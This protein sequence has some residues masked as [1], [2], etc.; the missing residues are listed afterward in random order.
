MGGL[1]DTYAVI[2]IGGVQHI[3]E[4]GRWYTC[5][6]LEVGKIQTQR[7]TALHGDVQVLSRE[8][9]LAAVPRAQRRGAPNGVPAVQPCT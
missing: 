4:E 8:W 5:N 9:Q 2:D 6:R 7:F 3:V 1:G